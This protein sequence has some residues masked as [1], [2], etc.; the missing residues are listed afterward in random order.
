MSSP[1]REAIAALKPGD[2]HYMAYVGPPTQYD[3]MGATQFRLLCAL[4]LRARH[5]L[6]DFG[7]GSLRAGRLF[8]PYLEP[9]RYHGI[10]PNRW[11]IDEAI[12]NELGEDLIRIKQPRFDHNDRFDSSVFGCRF[13]Y[14]VAQSIFSHAGPDLIATALAGFRDALEDHGLAAVTFIESEADFSGSGW[15]YPDC[16]AYRPTTIEA[17]A[18]QAGLHPLRLPWYHPRQSWY[19]LARSPDRLP[20]ADQRRHLTGVVLNDP[21]FKASWAVPEHGDEASS[22]PGWIARLW[23]RLGAGKA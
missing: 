13:D 6:L 11:L 4:G 8:I 23:K 16:V 2:P 20:T 1:P 10:E 19:L 18:R 9:G 7:C 12:E 3:F 5:R 17:M 14:I 21:A 15:I 22:S